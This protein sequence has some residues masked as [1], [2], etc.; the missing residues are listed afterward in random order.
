MSIDKSYW[1]DFGFNSDKI[2]SILC[3]N[4]HKGKLQ[5]KDTFI[6]AQTKHSKEKYDSECF[7]ETDYE[8]KFCGMLECDNNTCKEIITVVG[9]MFLD[10]ISRYEDGMS[11]TE[12][13]PF[14]K[15]E[16][17]A[18]QLDIFELKKKYPLKVRNALINSF[19]LFFADNESCA[20]KIR[21]VVE[22]LLDEL[23]IP[24]TYNKNNKR[25]NYFLHK[26]IELFQSKEQD[27]GAL[28]LSIKWIGNYGSHID[29][30]SKSDLIDAFIF[31][32]SVLDKLYDDRNKEL[33]KLSSMINKRKKPASKIRK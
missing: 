9:T 33:L 31:L 12:W 8:E 21:I 5:I 32:Q 24:R 3:P 26:R 19:K 7:S 10:P 17:F 27:L 11:Y 29:K 6:S 28:M 14:F 16:Y 20:N 25:K 18:P 23:K 1:I 30:L 15:P 22:V 2:P 4:C 13:R